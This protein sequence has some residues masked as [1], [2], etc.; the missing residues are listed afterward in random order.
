MTITKIKKIKAIEVESYPIGERS[1]FWLPLHQDPTSCE[2]MVPFIVARGAHPGP[3][4][5]VSAAVHG[6]ELNGMRIIHHLL[7][8]MDL[9]KLRGALVCAP[10][11]NVPSYNLGIR[12]FPDGL[13]LNHVFP[14]RKGGRPAE[15]YARA[16]ERRFLPGLDYLV[17]IHTASEGRINTMYVRADISSSKARSMSFD[18]NPQIILHAKSGDGT[19]RTAARRRG[20]PAITVEAGNPSVLQGRMVYEGE[21]GVVNVMKGLGMI[22]SVDEL[23]REPVV[24]KSSRWLRTLS[25][26]LLETHFK[27]FQRVEKKQLLA[28]T[29]DPFGGEVSRYY[30]PE[31]GIVIGMATNPSAGSGTRFCHLGSIGDVPLEEPS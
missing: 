26:G 13:D 6:N 14:G 30:A 23:P 12:R 27:L 25:G 17:D 5:G 15:Q 8:A 31:D 11:V 4:L 24:C 7:Q 16:F 9:S 20:I 22:D 10:I 1:N 29:H 28:V 2:V 18:F 19:L 21:T 3:T